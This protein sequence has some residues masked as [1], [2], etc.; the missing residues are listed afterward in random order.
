MGWPEKK[1]GWAR[2]LQLP[3]AQSGARYASVR[4]TT[5]LRYAL[6]AQQR[7]NNTP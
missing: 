1:A 7:G 4:D 5:D 3:R 2:V 6:T